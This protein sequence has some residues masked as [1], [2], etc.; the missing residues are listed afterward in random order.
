MWSLPASSSVPV[1]QGG[2]CHTQL[3]SWIFM[4]GIQ[5]SGSNPGDRPWAPGSNSLLSW[6]HGSVT[7][8]DSSQQAATPRAQIADCN[9]PGLSEEAHFLA[10]K[11]LAWD[12][13]RDPGKGSRDESW[14]TQSSSSHSPS[15]QLS[16]ISQKKSLYPCL[17]PSF[18]QQPQRDT[19]IS[20]GS[21][22]QQGLH[23]WVSQN[24]NHWRK[25]F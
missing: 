4:S 21:R 10:Q 25:H 1:S 9:T 13:P 16:G 15:L 20:P 19:S 2:S 24:D 5:F 23:L 6:V 18:L 17:V 12:T 22:S 3:V 14:W 8:R 7:V 11:L